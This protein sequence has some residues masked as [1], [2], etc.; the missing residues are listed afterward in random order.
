[1]KTEL[2]AK[3]K[4]KLVRSVGPVLTPEFGS[5][6]C[7][8][9]TDHQQGLV[10]GTYEPALKLMSRWATENNI[11]RSRDTGFDQDACLACPTNAP[12][13]SALCN[14][15]ALEIAPRQGTRSP[16]TA[17]PATGRCPVNSKPA[18]S[19]EISGSQPRPDPSSQ[20]QQL[21][22]ALPLLSPAPE[23]RSAPCSPHRHVRATRQSPQILL[24]TRGGR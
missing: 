20:N 6:D 3:A 11:R 10:Q 18:R 15:A 24:G 23:G 9:F 22:K 5:P 7:D 1:M 16:R 17:E 21:G 4:I 2:L 19:P 12:A 13:N 8:E 14:C